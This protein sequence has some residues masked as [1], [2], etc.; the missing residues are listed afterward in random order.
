[1]ADFSL[2]ALHAALDEERQ[3]RGLTWADVAI[4]TGVAAS[5]ARGFARGGRTAFPGVVRL[6][7]WLRRP[8]ADFV[9][10]SDV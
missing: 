3:A 2:K 6:T 9:R 7:A 10:L 5:H 8:V 4:D 1:M